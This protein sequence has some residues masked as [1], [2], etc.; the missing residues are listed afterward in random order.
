MWSVGWGPAREKT[1][2]GGR[3]QIMKGS[4]GPTGSL[5]SFLMTKG[6]Q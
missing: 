6:S 4:V 1:R 2:G 5:D 3:G